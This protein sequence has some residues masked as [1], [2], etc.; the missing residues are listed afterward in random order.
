MLYI[1][2]QS[3]YDFP[4][5]D[6]CHNTENKHYLYKLVFILFLLSDSGVGNEITSA[7]CCESFPVYM[8]TLICMQYGVCCVTNTNTSV[9]SVQTTT[10]K[11]FC[12]KWCSLILSS[13]LESLYR[14]N[15]IHEVLKVELHSA[16][17]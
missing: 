2:H 11:L 15:I 7:E 14:W 17:S 4:N 16:S 5:D 8:N 10:F 1:K 12:L 3:M 6:I 9:S 13:F